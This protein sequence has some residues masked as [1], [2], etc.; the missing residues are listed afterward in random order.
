MTDVLVVDDQKQ[1]MTNLAYRAIQQETEKRSR[2]GFTVK[3]E[4]NVPGKIV[5]MVNS[6]TQY[7][8]MGDGSWRK[9]K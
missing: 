6:G 5:T 9:I 4:F 2:M 3:N 8:V 7:E 1:N